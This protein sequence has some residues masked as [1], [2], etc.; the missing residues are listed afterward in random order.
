MTNEDYI[1]GMIG[2]RM[3]KY[4]ITR[5]ISSGSFG[6]VFEARHYK[7]KEMVALKIPIKTEEKDGTKSLLEES[8]I[9]KKIYKNVNEEDKSHKGIADVKLMRVKDK[10]ILVMDLLGDSLE[11]IITKKKKIGLKSV[12]YISIKLLNIVKFIHSA[13]YIHRDIKPDNFVRGYDDPKKWYCIDYGLAKSYYHKNGPHIP[14]SDKKKFCGTARYASIAA[15]ECVEQSR[16]D[17]LESLG[18]IFVYLYKGKLPWQ[19]IKHKDKKEKYRLIGEHKKKLS[20]E[21]LC[22]GMPKEFTVFLKYVRNLDFDEKPPYSAFVKMFQ[23]LYD[24]RN[25]KNDKLEWE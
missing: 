23:K 6:D 20:E 24:S 2:T 3:N 16:K 8:K 19:Q 12:I 21:E 5:Y 22:E 17:D 10:K 1:K 11:T 9:Y 15:H 14:Y 13:G 7:T 4:I 25:Y 18:Y